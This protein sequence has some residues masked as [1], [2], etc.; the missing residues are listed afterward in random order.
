MTRALQVIALLVAF[1]IAKHPAQLLSGP[2]TP[3]TPPVVDSV[4]VRARQKFFGAENVD[5]VGA[6]KKD[7]V[8]FSWATNTTYAVSILGRIVLLD[9]YVTRLELVPGRTPF[10]IQDLVA[11][12]P[13]VIVLGHG[14]WDHAD[15]AAYIAKMTGATLV[16]SPETC[17]EMQADVIRMFNDPNTVNG[18]KK[19]IPDAKPVR[20]I[21]V[22]SRG[23]PP[24][25]EIKHLTFL[26]PTA[27]V[28]AFKHV[29][30]KALP[31]DNDYPNV[32]PNVTLDARDPQLY[33]IG[34]PLTPSN[35]PL[36]GQIDIRTAPSSNPPGGPIALF[37]DF[38]VRSGNDFTF[39]WHNT[40]GPIKEG[41]APDGNWGPAVGKRLFQL[42]DS[43]PPTD[44][45]FGSVA[46][47]N[48]PTNGHRDPIM[49]TL[50]LKPQIF[51]PMHMTEVQTEGASLPLLWTYRQ[52]R[53]AMGMNPAQAPEIRWLVDPTDYL[54]PQ[55][56]SPADA[57][58]S[59][60][61]KSPRVRQSC[62]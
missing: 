53:Q 7:K 51:V 54:R 29:H 45:E 56:Y 15:N 33:P 28:I 24:G 17:D 11:L 47:P 35:P 59:N 26:E 38:V 39:V 34:T 8:I 2:A 50:H 3:P 44:V 13:E 42:I 19:I 40:S 1:G 57:R 61:L 37:F 36:A 6:V 31:H 30:S 41:I 20:C 55:V 9:S 49:Y 23:S 18:G 62:R 32:T 60:P 21:E 14:H 48:L 52:Q 25:S 10:V 12:K 58:W 22:V 46:T 16:A 43:L 4:L 27:C 5:A